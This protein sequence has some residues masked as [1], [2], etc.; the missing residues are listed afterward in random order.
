MIYAYDEIYLAK[1]RQTF[2]W[3]LSYA[4][5][6][7]NQDVDQFYSCFLISPYANAFATGNCSVIAGMSGVELARKVL[8]YVY[9][10]NEFPQP[11]YK[12]Q[13]SREY[14]LGFYLS[15]YQWYRNLSFA[16]CVENI[17]MSQLLCLYPKYHEMD[18][19]QFVI[20]MD[21]LLRK[22]DQMTRLKLYRQKVGLSQ[23]E[24]AE[25][26]EIPVRTIQ[27]YEQGQKDINHAKVEYVIRLAKELYCRPE[28]LLE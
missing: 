26:T 3:M 28:E 11:D 14:W 18:V 6:E 2:G 10:K 13:R 20:F 7:C 21:D 22:E 23:R 4:C 9:G 24:L 5:N 12:L 25:R 15:Y 27:Q 16:K 19:S 8:H 17:S 1:A